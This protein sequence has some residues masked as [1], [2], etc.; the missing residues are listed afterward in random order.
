MTER[1]RC[2]E[3]NARRSP[4]EGNMSTAPFA[5]RVIIFAMALTILTACAPSPSKPA[6]ASLYR[7][8]GGTE[9]I[10]HVVDIFLA[11]VDKDLRI[12]LFFEKTDHK[13]LRD[14]VIAQFCEASGG[15]CKYIGR[16][17]EESHSGL[18][19]TDADFNAF[20]EDLVLSLDEV[21]VPKTTQ[22]KLLALLGPMKPQVVGQ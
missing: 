19:L 22:D 13:D 6:H 11:R 2:R 20:V 17:M 10:T 4:R 1:S 9:G 7:E 5:M 15:P 14:L 8:L 12:N 18:N 3:K 21:K 16:S